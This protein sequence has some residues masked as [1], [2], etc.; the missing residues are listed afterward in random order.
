MDDYN[1][2]IEIFDDVECYKIYQNKNI[3]SGDDFTTAYNEYMA[4]INS[5][6]KVISDECCLLGFN[7]CCLIPFDEKILFKLY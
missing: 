4:A 7:D 3:G 1:K 5:L 2:E 6:K